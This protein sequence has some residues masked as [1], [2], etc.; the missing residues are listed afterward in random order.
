MRWLNGNPEARAAPTRVY[1]AGGGVSQPSVL[2]KVEPDYT[3]EARA[4]ETEG[5]VVLRV[6]V[7][8]DGLAHDIKVIKSLDA[9]LDEKAAEAV[10]KWTFK[11]GLLKGVPVDVVATLE[12]NFKMK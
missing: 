3:D 11:P 5:D 9:G 4:A 7:G 10:Q 1:R 6:V 12:I 8:L 2:S